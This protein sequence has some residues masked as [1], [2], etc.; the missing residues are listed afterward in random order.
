[1]SKKKMLFFHNCIDSYPLDNKKIKIK[2]S[3]LRTSQIIYFRYLHKTITT[4][5][6]REKKKIN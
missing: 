3:K 5:K 4:S 1:M 2:N 6:I